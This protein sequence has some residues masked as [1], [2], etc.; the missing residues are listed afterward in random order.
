MISHR[1]S[2]LYPTPKHL[3]GLFVADL[4][5][6]TEHELHG[7]IK[8][9]CG[10]DTFHPLYVASRVE[11]EG[12]H[13]LQV[14][15]IGEQWFCRIGA[16]CAS[17]GREHLLFD[18]HSHGWNGYVCTDEQV[19]QIP[20]PPFQEWSCHH[21]GATTHRIAIVIQGEDMNSA[22][23]EGEDTLTEADWFEAFGWFTVDL[24]CSAC[25]CGPTKILD[26]ET[27]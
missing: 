16:R 9:G 11:E 24:T 18:D 10:S 17:C 19:R 8:C 4:E 15:E 3:R 13:F 2:M 20:R 26:Y 6:S 23:G 25:G 12:Q 1:R 7:T 22:L 14:V 21:C 5:K 27:M